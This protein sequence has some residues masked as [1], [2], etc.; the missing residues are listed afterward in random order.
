M[1]KTTV[2]FGTVSTPSIDWQARALAAEAERDALKAEI[3]TSAKL[4][5]IIKDGRTLRMTFMRN[6]RAIIVESYASM[7]INTKQLQ[8]AL[9]GPL[10]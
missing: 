2:T 7:S 4:V 6:G 10:V 3:A 9:L 8:A 5:S 1:T